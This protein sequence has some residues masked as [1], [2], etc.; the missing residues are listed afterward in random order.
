MSAV[1]G[2]TAL[3]ECLFSSIPAPEVYWKKI[4]RDSFFSWFFWRKFEFFVR[5][6]GVLPS[7]ARQIGSNLKLRSV[8]PLFDGAYECVGKWKDKE[9]HLT[10]NLS[11]DGKVFSRPIF[12]RFF[13]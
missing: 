12:G 8:E 3:F 6:D 11:V 7:S 4:G 1:K 9:I 10:A 2:N 13:I 5:S